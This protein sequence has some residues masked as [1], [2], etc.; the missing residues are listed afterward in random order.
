[1]MDHEH[2]AIRFPAIEQNILSGE[3]ISTTQTSLREILN[4]E[5]ADDPAGLMD[6]SFTFT[7]KKVPGA[8]VFIASFPGSCELR[9]EN[10]FSVLSEARLHTEKQDIEG[11]RADWHLFD[12]EF[13]AYSKMYAALWQNHQVLGDDFLEFGRSHFDRFFDA[14]QLT[15]QRNETFTTES[16]I[17]RL[18][19]YT[20]PMCTLDKTLKEEGLDELLNSQRLGYLNIVRL[21]GEGYHP[22]LDEVKGAVKVKLVDLLKQKWGFLQ[23]PPFL[24]IH[25]ILIEMAD[26]ERAGLLRDLYYGLSHDQ[27]RMLIEHL[28]QYKEHYERKKILIAPGDGA[29]TIYYE[30][31]HGSGRNFIH[32]LRKLENG[33]IEARLGNSYILYE[34]HFSEQGD[35]SFAV[36]EEHIKV[37]SYK[38][39]VPIIVWQKDAV[40]GQK[41]YWCDRVSEEVTSSNPKLFNPQHDTLLGQIVVAAYSPDVRKSLPPELCLEPGGRPQQMKAAQ[42]PTICRLF[43]DRFLQES[44]VIL[45]LES[46]FTG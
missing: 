25:N 26:E 29:N 40:T 17:R 36:V 19:E 11:I 39:L 45:T 6:T 32:K 43:S 41:T 42:V 2:E 10:L 18:L 30:N 3:I 8:K 35:I 15:S 14:I 33:Q 28:Y 1:M 31:H 9:G 12:S 23:S 22:K 46:L 27:R 16:G 24:P 7:V 20:P 4:S 38:G 37:D 34:P 44:S 13:R 5:A 21:L